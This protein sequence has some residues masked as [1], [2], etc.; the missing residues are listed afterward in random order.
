VTTFAPLSLS[1]RTAV[2]TGATSGI[3]VEIARGLAARGAQT[4]VVGR[5]VDRTAQVAQEIARSTGNPAVE[6]VSVTDLALMSDVR[7]LAQTLRERYP[8]LSILVNNAGAYFHQREVTSEGH[9]RTFALN[10]LAPFLLT[11]LLTD[12]L[13][14]NP[15]ARVVNVSS[16][17]HR[18]YRV[19]F[20]DLES[21]SRYSGFRVYGRSKLEI[22]L[23]TREFARRLAGS[24][25]SVNAVHPGF[26][27]SG[28]GQN[29]AGATKR[30]FRF[31]EALFAISVQRGAETPL[32]VA[33][34]P[35]TTP[36][37]GEYFAKCR[38]APASAPSQSLAD[39]R[40]LY[41]VCSEITGVDGTA[42]SPPLNTPTSG[43]A[44]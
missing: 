38:V 9:E 24:G 43:P 3:G 44:R 4:V 37:S 5:G 22:L 10:V 17:A 2:V 1:G 30:V 33:T 11:S 29:N 42:L 13:R 34:D 21:A 14:E 6:P 25:I 40:R 18:G 41:E 23:L 32:F 20:S 31:V 26:V 16:A 12:R 19:D 15:P 35:S 36:I 27:A 39:A 8:Q 28:F 7:A